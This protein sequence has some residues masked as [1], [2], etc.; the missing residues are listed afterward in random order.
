MFMMKLMTRPATKAGSV[1]G[2]TTRQNTALGRAPSV[3]AA[4]ESA[5][6]RPLN[7]DPERQQ[8]EHEMAGDQSD[9][10]RRSR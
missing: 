7:G 2:S 9:A 6:S 3:P 10:R 4:Q 1:I 8:H 5:G